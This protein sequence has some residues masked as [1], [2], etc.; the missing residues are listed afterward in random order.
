V[1]HKQLL[2]T[3]PPHPYR[4]HPSCHLQPLSHPVERKWVPITTFRYTPAVALAGQLGT[5]DC[6]VQSKVLAI[7]ISQYSWATIAGV[8]LATT[9]GINTRWF[10]AMVA[11]SLYLAPLLRVPTPLLLHPFRPALSKLTRCALSR[12]SGSLVKSSSCL[13]MWGPMIVSVVNMI[14]ASLHTTNV[15]ILLKLAISLNPDANHEHPVV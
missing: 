14:P 1:A 9:P 11:Y 12:G 8:D 15:H 2:N 4:V 7:S 13:V 5:I 3:A 10:M 6:Q